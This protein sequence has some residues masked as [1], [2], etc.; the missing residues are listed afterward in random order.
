MLEISLPNYILII[1]E[2][3][4]DA[5]EIRRSLGGLKKGSP[6]VLQEINQRLEKKIEMKNEILVPIHF[7][8]IKNPIPIKVGDKER[9]LKRGIGAMQLYKYNGKP[10]ELH[11]VLKEI[12]DYFKENKESPPGKGKNWFAALT[13]FQIII[14]KDGK[15][16]LEEDLEDG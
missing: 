11:I 1:V 14:G 8:I 2:A 9:T 3:F 6:K 13:N 4:Y 12:L 7:S 16:T 5:N 10:N 15:E